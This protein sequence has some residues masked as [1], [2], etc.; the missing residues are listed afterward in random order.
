MT[1]RNTLA[2]D[3][4]FRV[5]SLTLDQLRAIEGVVK[6]FEHAREGAI[7]LA[8]AEFSGHPNTRVDLA[9][10]EDDEPYAQFDVSDADAPAAKTRVF[11]VKDDK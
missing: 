1:E 3:L 4:A 6:A 8:R 2:R 10:I 9:D 5:Q 11:V 7:E